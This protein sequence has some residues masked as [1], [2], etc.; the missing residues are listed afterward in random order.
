M[1]T[2]SRCRVLLIEDSRNDARL[3][4]ETLA[5]ASGGPYHVTWVE[6][7][8]DG[9]QRLTERPQDFD[10][11]VS[12]LN[13]PDSSGMDTFRAVRDVAAQLP[14]IVFSGTAADDFTI[15]ALQE[16]AQDFLIKGEFDPSWLG[17]SLRYAIERKKMSEELLQG[18]MKLQQSNLRFHQVVEQASDA[19]FILD[20]T[21]SIVDVNR[22]ACESLNYTREELL[23]MS[24]SQ[25]DP[26]FDD[27]TAKDA[28]R[29]IGDGKVFAMDGVHQGKDGR[30]FPVETRISMLESHV[31]IAL[32]LV[33]DVSERTRRLEAEH[34]WRAR[35]EEFRIARH[36]QQH[37]FPANS[38]QLP[39]FDIDGASFP[40]NET[41]GDYYDFVHMIQDYWGVVI[42]D[43]SGKNI[44]AALLVAETH[45]LIRA[46]SQMHNDIEFLLRRVNDLLV[47]D[48]DEERFLT[49]FFARINP[50]TRTLVYVGAGH[51]AYVLR[52]SGESN[53]L[54]PVS[55]PLGIQKNLDFPASIARPLNDGE[56]LVLAT[57]GIFE[58]E[59]SQGQQ[60]GDTRLL[61]Q[62]HRNRHL[63]AR[64][65]V[66]AVRA[67]VQAYGSHEQQH[68]DIT[69]VLIKVVPTG[70]QP[71]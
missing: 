5:D 12:D 66:Q 48:T 35:Q 9:K 24:M 27:A 22:Q 29:Q 42:G 8:A 52:P 55:I 21:N 4:Q 15:R 64:E 70:D 3:F 36:I 68:D 6:K 37:F 1:T 51:H 61:D 7:L 60:Y 14:I 47:D 41:G 69:L 32:A 49:L 20:D 23:G 26:S 43:V 45:A 28:W 19:F 18:Q 25:V 39:G 11:V 31:R 59:N 57:D 34:K 65:I 67:D 38:P 13:L 10:I 63:S 16:G 33:R 17:R 53:L 30:T 46:F 50:R 2:A 62:V 40:A 71:S 54:E 56:I 58:A 44:G